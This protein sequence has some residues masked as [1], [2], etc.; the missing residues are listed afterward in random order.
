LQA[1]VSGE[2]GGD[3]RCEGGA[4][5]AGETEGEGAAGVADGGG[6]ELRDDGAEGS[7][8]EA[9]EG[10]TERHHGD[11]AD[12]AGDEHGG[13]DET[14]EGDGGGDPEHDTAATTLRHEGRD[15]DGEGEEG[16]VE[17]LHQEELAAA[18]AERGGAPGEREDSH[19]VEERKR[20][21]ADEDAGDELFG[22]IA[23]NGEDGEFDRLA[24][25]QGCAKDGGL[26][27]GEAD[28]EA[29][30][31]ED[32]TGEEWEAPAEGEELPIGEEAGEHKEDAA[33][34]EKAKGCAELREHAVPGALV[35][36][37]VL[38]GEEDSAT[39]LAAEAKALAEAAQREQEGCA[40]ADGA[41]GGQSADGDSG[42]AHGGEGEDQGGLAADAVAEVAEERGSDGSCQKGDA[43]GCQGGERGGG[44]IGRRKEE[45]GK[46]QH[47][48]G[49]VDV[50]VEE[51]DG[52]AD[53]AGEEDLVWGIDGLRR[54]DVT[55][56]HQGLFCCLADHGVR[57]KSSGKK[58]ALRLKWSSRIVYLKW[59]TQCVA[60]ESVA[61]LPWRSSYN[62][63][64]AAVMVSTMHIA[65]T[66]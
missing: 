7:V 19:Q 46:D 62:C 10:Q 49:G 3:V 4:E 33:G 16:D 13:Q 11:R 15:R 18:V 53:E 29:K 26:G 42:E 9:H 58:R 6:K 5:D 12:G 30:E 47:G 54:G 44:G 17:E 40:E 2:P 66:V 35:W 14:E 60:R 61:E 23:E 8:G 25:I 38:D 41:V 39:P 24:A 37:S 50:E 32:G 63:H 55:C 51:L 22:V 59:S 34:E 31:D 28:V 56:A 65:V 36:G 20:R 21:Q 1:V 57:D 52:G 48:G 27:D 45:A 64:E 43:K